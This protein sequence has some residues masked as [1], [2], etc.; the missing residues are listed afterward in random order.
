MIAAT[1]NTRSA[2]LARLVSR[3]PEKKLGRTQVMKLFY[4]LQELKDVPLGYDFR[5]FT[6]GPFDSEVLSDLATA[7]SASTVREETKIYS[8]GYGYEITPGPYA[9]RLSRELEASNHEVANL[10]DEV[11]R[12]FGSYSAADLELLSTILFVDREF[13][14]TGN[15]V[16]QETLAERVQQIKPHFRTAT[17]LYKVGEMAK[18][19][20]LHCLT[21][22]T[23]LSQ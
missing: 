7:C 8:R 21:P 1:S 23:G 14:K 20:W 17:I 6:Y 22:I 9:D 3:A 12:D 18:R 13:S 16:S 11:L 10:V 2:I 19:G 4:F 15:V 5:L